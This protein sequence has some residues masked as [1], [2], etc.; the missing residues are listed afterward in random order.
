MP[1][2]K[3]KLTP[4]ELRDRWKKSPGKEFRV[5]IIK[6]LQ[7]EETGRRVDW[8]NLS[9]NVN[10][11]EYLWIDFPGVG[12]IKEKL[13]KHDEY[14][15][16]EKIWPYLNSN[17]IYGDLRGINLE[18]TELPD[19]LLACTQCNGV[20][21]W[22]ANLEGADLSFANLE[23]ANL[24]SAH[25]EGVKLRSTNL[26]GADLISTN[27]EGARLWCANLEDAHLSGAYLKR[28][29]FS[30]ANLK[31]AHFRRATLIGAYLL[32]ANLEGAYL[33]GANLERACLWSTRLGNADLTDARFYFKSWWW[34]VKEFFIKTHII[35]HKR[36]TLFAGCE[37]KNVKLDS[38]PVL[39]RELLD[40]Q[41]LDRFAERHKILY[42]FWIITSNCGRSV[43]LVF[44]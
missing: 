28:A 44:L 35:S 34:R 33:M 13:V 12:E 21:L 15:F 24:S 7:N 14:I 11:K 40:E 8:E 1:D 6:Q 17:S 39:Y 36:P 18:E 23:G 42:P 22:K 43:S 20:F 10:G 25:L 4:K 41:Y 29:C 16:P 38:D 27:L 19:V 9:V 5:E 31:G 37:L 32:R 26:E 2:E 3:G 30:S